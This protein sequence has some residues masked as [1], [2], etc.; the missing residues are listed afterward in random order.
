MVSVDI[1][2]AHHFHI[3]PKDYEYEL[4]TIENPN[5][6]PITIKDFVVE[7]HEYLALHKV[8]LHKYREA[9]KFPTF[10]PRPGQL[11]DLAPNDASLYVE[12][13]SSKSDEKNTIVCVETVPEGEFGM[14]A[15]EIWEEQRSCAAALA[16]HRVCMVLPC[17]IST[18]RLH[19]N[20]P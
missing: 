17:R 13:V 11:S 16:S 5:G 15:E 6:S 12:V 4:L 10:E 8:V 3:I 18:S 9:V 20:D 2:A 1:S 14:S 7:T 19:I